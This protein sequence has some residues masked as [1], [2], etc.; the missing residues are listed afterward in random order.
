MSWNSATSVEIENAARR[1]HGRRVLDIRRVASRTQQIA[2]MEAQLTR[3][4]QLLSATVQGDLQAGATVAAMERM[5]IDITGGT[6]SEPILV[7]EAHHRFKNSLQF[8]ASMLRMQATRHTGNP[9]LEAELHEASARVSCIAKVHDHLSRMDQN[10]EF[11]FAHYLKGLCSDLNA[12]WSRENDPSIV[13]AAGHVLLPAD[14]AVT[15]GLITNELVTNAFK[16]AYP[17][18]ARG[19]VRVAFLP[20]E[21]GS[22]NLI[23][24]DSGAGWLQNGEVRA[25]TGLGMKLVEGLCRQLDA[26]LEIDRTPPGTCFTVCIPPSSDFHPIR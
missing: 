26:V 1:V 10:S 25:E 9:E 12:A 13:V 20:L 11:D 15:L 23:V 14:T 22:F 21:D 6:P 3:S 16:H 5:M 7:R 8:V 2:K 4:S 18:G 24:A 17:D 19:V